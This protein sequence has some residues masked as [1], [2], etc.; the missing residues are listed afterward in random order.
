MS[1]MMIAFVGHCI[2]KLFS[3]FTKHF[4]QFITKYT[5]ISWNKIK[6]LN[7]FLKNRDSRCPLCRKNSDR[8]NLVKLFL[9]EEHV[10]V[11]HTSDVEDIGGSCMEL[12]QSNDS[13]VSTAGK[14]ISRRQTVD[15]VSKVAKTNHSNA[16]SNAIAATGIVTRRSSYNQSKVPKATESN[17]N[18]NADAIHVRVNSSR[19]K[20][21]INRFNFIRRRCVAC[22]KRFTVTDVNDFDVCHTCL[23]KFPN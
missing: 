17:A 3:S 18:G 21:E 20:M 1:F 23:R 11:M 13:A 15:V 14:I 16:S 7:I 10:E 4:S 9:G 22:E 12:N 19:K 5:S 8:R 6:L 2:C